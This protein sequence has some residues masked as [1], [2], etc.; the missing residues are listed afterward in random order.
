MSRIEK[1]ID[2]SNL[3]K[4]CDQPSSTVAARVLV[5]DVGGKMVGLFEA[6]ARFHI[7]RDWVR[8]CKLWDYIIHTSPLFYL[9]FTRV[10]KD[11]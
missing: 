1:I 6:I 5:M 9:G 4:T 10:A 3:A 8:V 2:G 11:S 7:V